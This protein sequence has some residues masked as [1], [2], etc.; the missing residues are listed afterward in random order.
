MYVSPKQQ[1]HAEGRAEQQ[2][3]VADILASMRRNE[4][5]RSTMPRVEY[6]WSDVLQTYVEVR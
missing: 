6:R 3:I 1:Q 5:R 2:R 4:R